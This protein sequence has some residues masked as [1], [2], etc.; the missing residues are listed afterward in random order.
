MLIPLYITQVADKHVLTWPQIFISFVRS[1]DEGSRFFPRL[2][3]ASFSLSSSPVAPQKQH[4]GDA[5]A[6]APLA[7]PSYR[8]ALDRFVFYFKSNTHMV[9]PFRF[10]LSYTSNSFTLLCS[11]ASAERQTV[12]PLTTNQRTC[13]LELSVAY[14]QP[15]SSIFLSQ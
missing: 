6:F 14:F 11:T 5:D 9:K 12:F 2:L 7:P 15:T 3:A 8:S 4:D 13:L 10:V 1:K